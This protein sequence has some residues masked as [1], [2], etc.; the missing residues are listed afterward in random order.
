MLISPR[1][2]GERVVVVVVAASQSVVGVG[3]AADSGSSVIA[4]VERVRYDILILLGLNGGGEGGTGG[5]VEWAREEMS[6]GKGVG[7]GLEGGEEVM[8]VGEGRL[9]VNGGSNGS[10]NGGG[11]GRGMGGGGVRAG[12]EVGLIPRLCRSWN[13]C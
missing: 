2:A 3:V 5:G 7:R 11:G 12:R 13:G 4:T 8:G 10:G 9:V 6:S 1:M